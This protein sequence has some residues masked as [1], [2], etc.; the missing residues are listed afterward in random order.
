MGGA[1]AIIAAAR[2][3]CPNVDV[4]TFGCPRIS[5]ETFKANMLCNNRVYRFINNRDI[6][7][8]LPF[9]IM[10]YVHSGNETIFNENGNIVTWN[11]FIYFLKFIII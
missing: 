4:Y 8:K 7:T 5:N 10:G 9:V 6:V 2:L 11:R 3:K 1:L